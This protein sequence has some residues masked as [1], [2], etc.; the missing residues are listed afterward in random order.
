MVKRSADGGDLRAM[1][2]GNQ[3]SLV[4]SRAEAISFRLNSTAAPLRALSDPVRQLPALQTLAGGNVDAERVASFAS[5]AEEIAKS[6]DSAAEPVAT[7]SRQVRA[8][9]KRRL[10]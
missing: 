10:G 4:A 6:L 8:L 7:L 1:L 9:N 3:I 2:V 5:Q